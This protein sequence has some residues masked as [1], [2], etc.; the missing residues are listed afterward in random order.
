M[1]SRSVVF[2]FRFSSVILVSMV[3]TVCLRDIESLY[4]G[5]PEPDVVELN[6][7]KQLCCTYFP[8]FCR[9]CPMVVLLF[10]FVDTQRKELCMFI[11]TGV[12]N[13][14]VLFPSRSERAVKLVSFEKFQLLLFKQ[15]LLVVAKSSWHIRLLH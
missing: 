3:L 4:L 6:T 12:H 14:H 1:R 8:G 2:H 5:D 7:E 15:P 11:D 13:F 10:R 9:S